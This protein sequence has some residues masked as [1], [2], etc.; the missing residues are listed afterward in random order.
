MYLQFSKEKKYVSVVFE[1]NKNG[2]RTR[3]VIQS[4]KVIDLE[5]LIFQDKYGTYWQFNEEDKHF[6]FIDYLENKKI[7]S[8]TEKNNGA[9]LDFGIEYFLYQ[10]LFKSH[11]IN[12]INEIDYDDKDTIITLIIANI[13]KINSARDINRWYDNSVIQYLC[14]NAKIDDRRISE[15]YEEF[16]SAAIETSIFLANRDYLFKR[17]GLNQDYNLDSV[18]LNT[19]SKITLTDFW[20]HDGNKGHGIRLILLDQIGGMPIYYRPIYGNITDVVTFCPTL[21]YLKALDIDID[22]LRFDCGY[23][24][25]SNIDACYDS[26]NKLKFDFLTR[27]RSN[28]RIIKDHLDENFQNLKTKD[29]LFIYNSKV[30]YIQKTKVYVGKNKDKEAYLYIICDLVRSCLEL[31]KEAENMATNPYDASAFIYKASILGIFGLLSGKERSCREVIIAYFM[32]LPIEQSFDFLKNYTSLTPIRVY[33][34]ATFMGKLAIAFLT[35]A[36]IRM[37]QIDLKALDLDFTIFSKI[38]NKLKSRVYGDTIIIGDITSDVNNIFNQIGIMLPYELKITDNKLAKANQDY[39]Y[40]PSWVENI[41]NK[42]MDKRS[43]FA[44]SIVSENNEKVKTKNSRKTKYIQ[45]N[46]CNYKNTKNSKRGRPIGSRNKI[47]IARENLLHLLNMILVDKCNKQSIPLDELPEQNIKFGKKLNRKG[48]PVGSRNKI[49]IARE[50]LLQLLDRILMDRCTE[51]GISVE[52]ISLL[53]QKSCQ[54]SNRKG[55]K[56]G[57]RNKKTIM[58]ESLLCTL[59]YILVSR[60]N[61]QDD[62]TRRT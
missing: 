45:V 2:I 52:G 13:L 53:R 41:K 23:F 54:M 19:D 48:R 29:N 47:T 31:K 14:P 3:K 59:K 7:S 56:A 39:P 22:S 35:L 6:Y 10:F 60:S 4:G 50:G 44:T 12:V 38:L 34:I 37:I 36:I 43:G 61:V 49:T 16:S 5:R 20:N 32:R 25:E 51:Q 9:I 1:S 17:C 33:N 11:Y 27:V 42:K 40:I 46:T 62:F 58:R 57:S 55:R 15:F 8:N 18:G 26:N 30:F 21:S 28:S 24:S